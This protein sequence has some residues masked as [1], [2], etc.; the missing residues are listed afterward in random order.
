LVITGS[1]DNTIRIWDI[2]KGAEAIKLDGPSDALQSV[3]WNW[4]GSIM[5]ASGKDREL[6]LYDPRAG[7]VTN[8]SL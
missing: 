8:V 6:K 5:A 1:G 7:S 2:E 3:T 4:N